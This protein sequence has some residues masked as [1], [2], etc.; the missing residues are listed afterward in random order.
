MDERGKLLGSAED[1]IDACLKNYSITNTN[2]LDPS[3]QSFLRQKTGKIKYDC[4]ITFFGGY[5]EAERSVMLCL[6]EYVES[7]KDPIV[8]ELFSVVRVRHSERAR[9]SSKSERKLAHGD[10]LGSI[11]GLGIKRVLTGDILTRNDGADIVVLSDIADYRVR[12]LYQ[13][14]KVSVLCEVLPLEELIVPRGEKKIIRDTVASLRLDN[15]VASAFGLSRS[16][17]AEAVKRGIVFVNH[18]EADKVDMQVE[19]GALI[20]VRHK[21]RARLIEISGVSRKG[22]IGIVIER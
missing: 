18:I 13:V 21:G 2:F 7:E 17:A 9:V 5:E 12:E 3:Q 10:Y 22:R 1:K 16:K 4:K 19:E 20:N 6:P 8:S 15:V 14:G 11:L